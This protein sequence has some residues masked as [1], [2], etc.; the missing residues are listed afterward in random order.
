M[1]LLL[2]YLRLFFTINDYLYY[3]HMTIINIFMTILINYYYY[4]YYYYYI[5][6]GMSVWKRQRDF[7]LSSSGST[8]G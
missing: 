5:T 4:Y 3:F 2:L 7:T 1:F 6:R 8:K